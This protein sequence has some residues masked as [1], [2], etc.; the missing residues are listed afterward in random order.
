MHKELLDWYDQHKRDLPWRESRDPYRVL[1][2]ELML[3]QTVVASVIEPYRRWMERF[4]TIE[5]LA[6]ANL[7]DVLHAWQGLGYYRRAR[8]LHQAAKEISEHGWPRDRKGMQAVPGIGPYTAGAVLS[9]AFDLPEPLV[10]GNVERVYARLMADDTAPPAL[11]KRAWA[12]AES[13]VPKGR[14]GDWNQALMELGATV[15]RPRTPQCHVCPWQSICRATKEDVS[16]YPA[17]KVRP[18]MREM[19]LPLAVWERAGRYA[20]VRYPEGGWWAGLYGFPPAATTKGEEIG[21]FPF[22]V[23][24][25]RL[26]VRVLRVQDLVSAVEWFAPDEFDGLALP[27]LHRRAWDVIRA[28]QAQPTLA[29]A[30]EE[31]R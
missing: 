21:R 5:A 7:D 10:D 9:I 1:V 24:R 17:P 18:E 2:S 4:P 6:Q 15:C 20:L 31:N 11:T 8:L 16:R 28:R 23:T 27:A 19:D 14:P 12:W 3:Q 30:P 25:H 26:T 22:V 29:I 13:T